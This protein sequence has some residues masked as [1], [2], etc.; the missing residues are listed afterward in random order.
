VSARVVAHVELVD[1]IP[2]LLNGKYKWVVR[3]YSRDPSRPSTEVRT[4][5]P[6]F[7]AGATC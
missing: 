1:Q 2:A 4:R 5:P 3:E 7:I 6:A